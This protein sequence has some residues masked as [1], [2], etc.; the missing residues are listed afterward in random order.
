MSVP[1]PN[2]M[3]NE[4]SPRPRFYTQRWDATPSSMRVILDVE[5]RIVCPASS[6]LIPAA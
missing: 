6:R 1:S 5:A 2:L 3:I 4:G